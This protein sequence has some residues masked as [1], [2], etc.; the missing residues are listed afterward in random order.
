MVTDRREEMNNIKK[1]FPSSRF[2]FRLFFKVEGLRN[3]IIN[4][5]SAMDFQVVYI[6]LHTFCSV[7]LIT[8]HIFSGVLFA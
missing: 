1:K 2:I 7:G 8:I 4:D 6:S 5:S 3:G